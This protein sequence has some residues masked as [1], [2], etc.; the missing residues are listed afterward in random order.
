MGTPDLGPAFEADNPSVHALVARA[1][2]RRPGLRHSVKRG[3]AD[4]SVEWIS[5]SGASRGPPAPVKS[6]LVA[7]PNGTR[8]STAGGAASSSAATPSPIATRNTVNQRVNIAI[9]SSAPH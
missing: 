2:E 3:S 4:T 7:A 9:A 6:G 5:A 8:D 1:S